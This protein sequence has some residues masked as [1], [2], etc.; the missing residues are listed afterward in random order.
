MSEIPGAK[1][2]QVAGLAIGLLVMFQQRIRVEAAV[3]DHAC[4]AG[5]VVELSAWSKDLLSSINELLAARACGEIGRA[6]V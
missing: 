3:A 5:F 1:V 2:L 4:E 6:H